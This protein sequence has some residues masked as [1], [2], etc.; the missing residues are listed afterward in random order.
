MNKRRWILTTLALGFLATASLAVAVAAYIQRLPDPETAD[1]QGL[2]RW[3]VETDVRDLSPDLQF[4]LVARVERELLAGINLADAQTQLDASQRERLLANADELARCWFCREAE[5][6]FAE[7]AEQRPALLER[8]IAEIQRLRIVEQL[9]ALENGA[10]KK[11]DPKSDVAGLAAQAARME[12]WAS[13]AEPR[14]REQITQYF[15][16]IRDRFI[17]DRMRQWL[18]K[19]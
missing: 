4:R 3:L 10:A 11:V 19:F 18:P 6:Y 5:R 1:R 2:F 7:P 13:D 17:I 12:R 14:Q 8:Q 9:A 15:A 16:A